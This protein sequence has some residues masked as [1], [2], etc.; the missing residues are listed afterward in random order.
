MTAAPQPEAPIWFLPMNIGERDTTDQ[1]PDWHYLGEFFQD[2]GLG[3][4]VR[5]A[6]YRSTAEPAMHRLTSDEQKSY[7]ARLIAVFSDPPTAPAAWHP[8][9]ERDELRP[10]VEKLARAIARG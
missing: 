6:V 2:I 9:W 7:G 4:R 5:F 1:S 10:E 8:V 3:D